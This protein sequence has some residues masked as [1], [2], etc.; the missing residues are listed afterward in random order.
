MSVDASAVAR[1]LGIST[2]FVN[3]R[4]SGVAQLPQRIAVIAQGNSDA[5]FPAG[6]RQVTSAEEGGS[7]WGWG[8]PIHQALR[9]LFPRNGDGV[10]TIPVT[11]Y[12]LEDA[13]TGVAAS[14]SIAP[15]GS[16]TKA[17]SYRVIIGGVRSEQFVIPVGASVADVC[18]S[19]A[20]A[21]NAVLEMPV[22]ATAT[23]TEVELEAKWKGLTGNDITVEVVGEDLGTT[24][25]VT[26]MSGGLVNP[27]ITPAL[28]QIGNV[29]ETLALNGLGATDTDALD[30]LQTAGEARWGALVRKPF[31][32][33]S[34]STE[35][36]VNTATAV[37]AARR[38]DHIN[39]QLVAPGSKE[40]PIAVA[41]RQ[42]A[43]IAQVANSNPPTDYGSQRVDGI[44]PGADGDQWDYAQRDLA[45]KAGSSTAEVKDGVLCIGDVVTYYRPTGDPNPAY[46]YVVDIVKL[47]NIIFNID[48]I[49]NQPE[50]D[51][52]PLIP[53]GQPTVTPKARQPSAASAAVAGMLDALAL[54]AIISDPKAAKARTVAAI[55]PD[56]PKRLNVSI[57]IQ[58]SGNTN[59]VSVDLN[60]GF[61]FGTPAVVG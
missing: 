24:F 56:N 29:W 53:N 10:G 48:L 30:A 12:P 6:K 15:T 27:D 9:Q 38:D 50:W 19:M 20:A 8:S 51:G 5:V 23:T 36:N 58:L 57:T 28:E 17:A 39:S 59:I 35:A 49:F 47:Q 4:E 61:Y 43:R 31:V 11:V 54:E 40:L 1:T 26:A 25:A 22:T 3:L 16:Q 14:G 41:A 21:I 42:L 2:N 45:V 18:T 32:A 55:D 13:A 34:G 33:F 52:A 44:T 46:R 60:F 37:P 7:I